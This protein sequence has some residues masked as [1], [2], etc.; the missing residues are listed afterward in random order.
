MR[1]RAPAPDYARRSE[2]PR[3]HGGADGSFSDLD[4]AI[5]QGSGKPEAL[6][7]R[8]VAYLE[9]RDFDRAIADFDR[10]IKLEPRHA[11][12]IANRAAAYRG[13]GDFEHAL[14]DY[15]LLSKI[16]PKDVQAYTNRGQVFLQH[17][18]IRPR[19]PRS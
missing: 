9:R 13:I 18:R 7:R 8:G 6:V 19:H 15:E 1:W 16:N 14:Q 10:A 12:A 17:A 5:R 11:A 2:G 3:A 4:H